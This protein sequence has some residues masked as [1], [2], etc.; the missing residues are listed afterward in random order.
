[1]VALIPSR[2][3]AGFLSRFNLHAVK[4]AAT[5][6]EHGDTDGLDP[7][8]RALAASFYFFIFFFHPRKAAISGHNTLRH[9]MCVDSREAYL[10]FKTHFLLWLMESHVMQPRAS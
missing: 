5:S 8:Y 6:A 3:A 1:M 4:P 2:L 10:S 7:S 9:R